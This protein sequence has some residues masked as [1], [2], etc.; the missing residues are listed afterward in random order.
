MDPNPRS[1]GT[2]NAKWA[3]PWSP[4]LFGV[5]TVLEKDYDV[6]LPRAQLDWVLFMEESPA[7]SPVPLALAR[8]AGAVAV[9]DA[10][11]GPGGRPEP[12]LRFLADPVPP[13]RFVRRVVRSGAPRELATRYLRERV[14][15]D[16]AFLVQPGEE[17]TVSPGRVVRVS[18]RPS[19]LELEV[20]V[21]GPGPA[22]LLACRPL[23]ATREATLDGRRVAVDEALLGFTGLSIPA[24][25]HVVRLQP[26][27]TWLIIATVL[28]MTGLATT[29]RL[30]RRGPRP[31]GLTR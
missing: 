16:A 14:P 7:D 17:A 10:G 30:L 29:L 5:G 11:P 1:A 21:E 12:R 3:F 6:T 4:G 18:D 28:S 27:L 15:V 23:V 22:Y 26:S 20:E 13:F 31:D 8:A 2:S 19:R 24:G 9:V 25:R